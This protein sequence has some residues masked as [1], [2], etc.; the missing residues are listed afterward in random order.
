MTNKNTK[1]EKMIQKKRRK[2]IWRKLW[3][4]YKFII[5]ALGVLLVLLATSCVAC[6]VTL[7]DTY[8]EAKSANSSNAGV[9]DEIT[10]SNADANEEIVEGEDLSEGES[11]DLSDE[12]LD[13]TVAPELMDESQD[14]ITL[15]IS[16]AG[17]CTL[18][19]DENFDDST[20]FTA[21]YNEQGD[22]GYFLRKVK[23]V[24]E[25]DDLTIVNLEGTL[26]T[27]DYREDKT[28]AF[29]GKPSYTA[30]LTEGAVEAVNLAN[31][32]SHDYGTDSYEDTIAN[33]DEAGIVNFGYDRTAVIDVKGV[34]VGLVGVYELSE[35]YDAED[36]LRECLN[37]VKAEGA[38]LIVVSFHWGSEKEHYPDDIQ[39]TLAHV[40]IDE[41]AHLVVGHHPH[42]LQGI[43]VYKGRNIVYS[44][45]N[46][47][48]GGNSNPSDKDTMIFQQTF[49][50]QGG[51]VQEDNVKH[52]IPCSLSSASSYNNYQPCI[53]DGED[54]QRVLDRIDTYSSGLSS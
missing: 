5:I 28:F 13:N 32:H 49:T 38:Q 18:G 41:G 43:E 2:R 23:S 16:A 51:I 42:V 14:M 19:T 26:T 17:D 3:R 6:T 27:S 1:R 36:D 35:G 54:A 20:N 34:S 29:K 53:L 8:K 45:G 30:I 52:I 33:L 46:F 44:L 31:N 25:S 4:Q 22:P 10:G 12:I 11:E 15:T 24:F 48:F 40:A 7:L 39:K 9:S 21:V 37:E 47:C 50:I